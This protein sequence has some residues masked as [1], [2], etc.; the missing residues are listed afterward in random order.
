MP[1][2]NLLLSRHSHLIHIATTASCRQYRA[3]RIRITARAL[4]T[5]SEGMSTSDE[6]HTVESGRQST[7]SLASKSEQ[8]QFEKLTADD[9]SFWVSKEA[10]YW[11]EIDTAVRSQKNTNLYLRANPKLTENIA[12]YLITLGQIN[13]ALAPIV[14]FATSETPT[15]NTSHFISEIFAFDLPHHDDPLAEDFRAACLCGEA[16]SAVYTYRT[17]SRQ[18]EKHYFR[19]YDEGINKNLKLVSTTIDFRASETLKN[20]STKE[21]ELQDKIRNAE[22]TLKNIVA[23]ATSA[24]ALSEPVKFWE[25]RKSIHN[26]NANRYGKYASISAFVFSCLLALTILYEYMSGTTHLVFGYE[27]TLPK[28]LSGIATILLISTA[29]IWATRIFVKLMMANLTLETESIERA[30]MI[31]TF[32]AMKAA[33]SSIAQEAELLFYTTLFRPSNNVISEES[34]APE[35]GKILDAILRAK[36]DKPGA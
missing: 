1:L 30:T 9:F 12:N 13:N 36:P 22:D 7:Y 14:S 10:G 24:I 25:D 35:F 17:L 3:W 11:A 29:G 5:E 23:A 19:G 31:K 6:N 2:P 16:A 21:T 20:L 34:T 27:F 33:E 4:R 32:V 26:A 15:L 8:E 28:S 18:P